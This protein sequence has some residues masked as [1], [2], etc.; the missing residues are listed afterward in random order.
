MHL[1]VIY[2]PEGSGTRWL[3]RLSASLLGIEGA[4]GWDGHT[5]IAGEARLFDSAAGIVSR[6]SAAVCHVSLPCGAPGSG[7]RRFVPH[8]ELLGFALRRV[9][10]AAGLPDLPALS[11]APSYA[12]LA[13][14]PGCTLRSKIRFAQPDQG[15][16][17]REQLTAFRLLGES[18]TGSG[19]GGS[20]E[21]FSY[22]AAL[23]M[24]RQ[25]LRRLASFLR[26]P[27]RGV[28]FPAGLEPRD[29]NA[30]YLLP[31]ADCLAL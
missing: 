30:K 26:L 16:A 29:E 23:S 28:P 5:A 24:P 15:E 21:L 31:A 8:G 2:G 18:L 1:F 3:A 27:S 10:D 9:R 7:D 17:A 19:S 25:F 12:A 14:D 6:E 13:R 22:E 4:A 11:R 20:C